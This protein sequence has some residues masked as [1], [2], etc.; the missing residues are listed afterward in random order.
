M[1]FQGIFTIT[2]HKW[3][4]K[5]MGAVHIWSLMAEETWQRTNSHSRLFFLAEADSD[6]VQRRANAKRH[7]HV[8][9]NVGV[10]V[11]HG[12][13]RQ[14]TLLPRSMACSLLVITRVWAQQDLCLESS[15]IQGL[16]CPLEEVA[17]ASCHAREEHT[18]A[19]TPRQ[20]ESSDPTDSRG[21]AQVLMKIHNSRAW[22]GQGFA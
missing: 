14:G 13:H 10:R 3:E 4:K 6:N 19:N 1:A 5:K 15:R 21:D 16:G 17:R 22:W 2:I 8:L 9:M 11:S 20:T 18:P 12:L 7:Q